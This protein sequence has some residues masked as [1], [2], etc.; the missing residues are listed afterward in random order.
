MPD[1][2]DVNVWVALCDA[3]HTANSR[4]VQYWRN[5]AS[6]EIVFCRTTAL[7]LTRILSRRTSPDGVPLSTSESWQRYQQWRN[8]PGVSMMADPQTVEECLET[9]YEAGIVAP[10]LSTD[11][12]LAAFAISAGLRLVTLDRD[13][14]RFPGLD[15]LRLNP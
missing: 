11:A 15:M 12:Y 8:V 1:L 2:P 3:G 6:S 5:E 7:G 14:E 13:F 9:F 4:A 10:K